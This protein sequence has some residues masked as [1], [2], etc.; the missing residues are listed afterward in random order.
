M[1][2]RRDGVVARRYTAV[3]VGLFFF[4]AGLWLAGVSVESELITTVAMVIAIGTLLFGVL[5]RRQ[6]AQAR[7][8][9]AEADLEAEEAEEVAGDAER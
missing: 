9:A 1:F 5:L 2:I 8:I 4:A 6:A 3:R 7:E